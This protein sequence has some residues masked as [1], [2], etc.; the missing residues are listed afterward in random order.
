MESE[1][2]HIQISLDGSQAWTFLRSFSVKETHEYTH[3]LHPYPAKIVPQIARELIHR[4]SKR[5]DIVLDP[6]CGS[7]GVLVESIMGGRNA[8]GV[9]VNRL[10]LLLAKVK[11]TFIDDVELREKS[12]SLQH[13]INGAINYHNKEY[14]PLIPDIPNLHHWFKPDVIRQLGIIKEAIEQ[15][16]SDNE[17]VKDFFLVCFSNTMYKVSNIRHHD[18]PF[19]ARVLHKDEM[20][21]HNPNAFVEFTRNL[22]RSV[23]SM[24]DFNTVRDKESWSKTISGD[25]RELSKLLGENIPVDLLVT[26]PPYGEETNTMDYNRFSKLALFWL[27]LGDSIAVSKKLSLGSLSRLDKMRDLPFKSELLSK[28]LAQIQHKSSERSS[29]V[30]E[31]FIDYSACLNEMYKVLKRGSICCIVI[32]DRSASDV[33][34]RNGDITSELCQSIGFKFVEMVRRKMYMYSLRSNVVKFEDIVILEK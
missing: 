4:Y 3:G 8:V 24:A 17:D 1:E 11:T 23:M 20:K 16:A 5:G 33:P 18:N 13:K 29:E 19:F 26:S 31:F 6:F 32:G 27:G 2:E 15:I 9:D 30:R 10:A 25:S 12:R 28:T 21:R 22:E 14:Q 34:I 7:G